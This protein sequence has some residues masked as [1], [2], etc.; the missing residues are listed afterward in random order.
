M[1]NLKNRAIDGTHVQEISEEEE[2]DDED[3]DG[4]EE[5]EEETEDE[6]GDEEASKSLSLCRPLPARDLLRR[7]SCS[8]R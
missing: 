8:P 6:S 3:G 7:L 5:D 2:S 4:E 1:G